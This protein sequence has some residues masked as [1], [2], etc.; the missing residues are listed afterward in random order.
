MYAPRSAPP[1]AR[2]SSGTFAAP[3]TLHHGV[4]LSCNFMEQAPA[5]H[6][7]LEQAFVR[8]LAGIGIDPGDNRKPQSGR[9]HNIL[10]ERHHARNDEHEMAGRCYSYP[11]ERK[12]ADTVRESTFSEM[13]FD[14]RREAL[15]L[16]QTR[17]AATVND[18]WLAS[19]QRRWD[20]SDPAKAGTTH[21][22]GSHS[23]AASHD[24]QA[25]RHHQYA[26]GGRRS[27]ERATASDGHRQ[28][29]SLR[30]SHASSV[31]S[32]RAYAYEARGASDPCGA[33]G[34]CGWGCGHASGSHTGGGHAGGGREPLTDAAD[35]G[36]GGGGWYHPQLARAHGM[37]PLHELRGREAGAP[38]ASGREA[39]GREAAAGE[40][41]PRGTH[42]EAGRAERRAVGRAA[43]RG[44]SSVASYVAAERA[45]E[46]A[47]ERAAERGGHDAA[48]YGRVTLDVGWAAHGD[49][50][51]PR[52]HGR[53]L[54]TALGV[55]AARATLRTREEE[56]GEEEEEEGQERGMGREIGREVGVVYHHGAVVNSGGASS[57][58]LPLSQPSGSGGDGD[59][60]EDEDEDGN[61]SVAVLRAQARRRAADGA[62]AAATAAAAAA[63]D[64]DDDAAAAFI[65]ARAARAA[66]AALAAPAALAAAAAA[67]PAAAAAA[68]T[69][70]PA[71][72]HS[73]RAATA[74]PRTPAAHAPQAYPAS[75]QPLTCV[76]A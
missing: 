2:A 76:Y 39:G 59:E 15:A 29:A 50:A 25:W 74:G 23:T 3:P 68:A 52:L 16:R 11:A 22:A 32:D 70:R 5:R 30:H 56:E 49:E 60:D 26:G 37:P 62:L 19:L 51:A 48:S 69:S 53:Q 75:A 17:A 45:A 14:R 1:K 41:R 54:R 24:S 47:V 12:T 6:R 10:T 9:H 27:P 63:A 36:W 8:A 64:D 42:R 33:S 20:E 21:L 13:S 72:A 66:R 7:P 46:R 61:E 40:W 71:C 35:L 65:A 4:H 58:A 43:E 44:G 73:R 38:E 28:A 34:A 55:S 67:I 31:Q 57:F 18:P